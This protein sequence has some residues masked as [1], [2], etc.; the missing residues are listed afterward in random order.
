[1]YSLEY[2]ELFP[3]LA[4]RAFGG[5]EISSTVHQEFEI[6]ARRKKLRRLEQI[7]AFNIATQLSCQSDKKEWPIPKPTKKLIKMYI[8]TFS[9]DL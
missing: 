5:N 2:I 6:T 7:A 9:V 1:M 3:N 8:D 4:T